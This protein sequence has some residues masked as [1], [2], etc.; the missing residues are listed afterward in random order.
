MERGARESWLAQ[1]QQAPLCQ[2]LPHCVERM[3]AIQNREPA[4][5]DS[6]PSREHMR[7]VGRE[8]TIDPRGNLQTS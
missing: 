4:G 1:G 5:R 6:T 3:I 2:P 7:R 8:E